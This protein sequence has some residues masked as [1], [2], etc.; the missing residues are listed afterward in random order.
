MF[1]FLA[2]SANASQLFLGAEGTRE[3]GPTEVHRWDSGSER[4]TVFGTPDDPFRAYQ[5]VEKLLLLRIE[6]VSFRSDETTGV[7]PRGLVRIGSFDM[8]EIGRSSV[9]LSFSTGC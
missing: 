7:N 9:S 4:P 5:P 2:A 6:S 3:A 1:L 8:G